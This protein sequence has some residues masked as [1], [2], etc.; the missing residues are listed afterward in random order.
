[1]P[2]LFDDGMRR[3]FDGDTSIEE[4]FRVAFAT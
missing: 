2:L 1:M 3:A 4:V